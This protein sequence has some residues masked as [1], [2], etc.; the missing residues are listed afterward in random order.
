MLKEVTIF[1][2]PAKSQI[3]ITFFIFIL[4]LCVLTWVRNKVKGITNTFYVIVF[5]IS[6]GYASHKVSDIS[7]NLSKTKSL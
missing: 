2:L 3:V 7:V 4:Q 6:E 1:V 5:K